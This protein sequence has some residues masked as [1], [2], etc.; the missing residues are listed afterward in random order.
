MTM[1]G[2]FGV[3]SGGPRHFISRRAAL[4]LKGM[5]RGPN[6]DMTA[7]DAALMSTGNHI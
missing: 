1:N 5:W 2:S 3:G 4:T 7:G 6:D